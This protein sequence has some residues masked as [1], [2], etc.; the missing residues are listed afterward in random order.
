MKPLSTAEREQLALQLEWLATKVRENGV[1]ASHWALDR[2][3][4]HATEHKVD[5]R[6][7]G[8]W[9]HTIEVQFM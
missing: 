9:R 8:P 4:S 7:V 3:V 5:V 6:T 2:D 1:V